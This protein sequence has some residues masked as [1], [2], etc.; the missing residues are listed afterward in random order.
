MSRPKVW[1]V[2]NNYSV[3]ELFSKRGFEVV[4]NEASVLK[5]NIDLI[6]F[7]GGE[8]IN[9]VYYNEEKHFKTNCHPARDV[10]ETLIYEKFLDIPKVGICRGGQLLNVLS[11]GKMFQD[12]DGHRRHHKIIDLLLTKKKLIVPSGHHQM[13]IPTKD[14]VVLAVAFESTVCLS[15]SE[16]PHPKLK[17]DPEVIWIPKT[18]SLCY[19]SHPEWRLEEDKEGVHEQYFFSLVKWAFHLKGVHEN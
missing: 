9:P 4:F 8:D 1:V 11:G 14:S 2:G 16:P 3:Q 10:R 18:N 19:Q 15:C 6:C 17:Y 7:T 12:V 13:M 5:N